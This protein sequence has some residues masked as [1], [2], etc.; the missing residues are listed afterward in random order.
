MK[1]EYWVLAVIV[2]A[3][4]AVTVWFS[5]RNPEAPSSEPAVI[6][7]PTSL[8]NEDPN[9]PLLRVGLANPASENC[10]ALGGEPTRQVKPDGGEYSICVFED[11]LQCEEW[12]LLRGECPAGGV[13]VAE[14]ETAAQIYCAVTGGQVDMAADTCTRV[15]PIN[16]S[17]VIEE[18]VTC[19]L[20]AYYQGLCPLV[21]G[22]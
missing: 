7:E 15:M 2:L 1:K 12:A 21:L 6:T 11:N 14:Y 5:W 17:P 9:D 19:D 16:F 4:V 20:D 3:A 18:E 22:D 13:S 8:I 10:V